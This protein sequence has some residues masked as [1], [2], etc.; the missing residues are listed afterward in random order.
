MAYLITIKINADVRLY[1]LGW[2]VRGPKS[3]RKRRPDTDR[4]VTSGGGVREGRLQ[5]WMDGV[6]RPPN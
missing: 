6:I 5:R 1:R 3:S 2:F 4:S